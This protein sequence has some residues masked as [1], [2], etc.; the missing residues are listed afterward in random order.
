[1]AR[2]IDPDQHGWLD[3]TEYASIAPWDYS[4][5]LGKSKP[6]KIARNASRAVPRAV[7]SAA[8]NAG[9][10]RRRGRGSASK[11]VSIQKGGR[12]G[13]VCGRVVAPVCLALLLVVALNGQLLTVAPVD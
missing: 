8:K 12:C 11:V 2:R 1:M 10:T 7:G 9:T 4:M 3:D 5:M 13:V 6:G